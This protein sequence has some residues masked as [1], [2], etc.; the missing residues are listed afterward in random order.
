MGVLRNLY[1]DEDYRDQGHGNELLE[2]FMIEAAESGAEAVL[3]IA[4]DAE[5]N[6]FN[7]IEWYEGY[8]FEIITKTG[9]GPL[10]IFDFED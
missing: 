8:G 10:M 9:S 4:D 6:S 5:S 2:E 7:L 3:L 1:V